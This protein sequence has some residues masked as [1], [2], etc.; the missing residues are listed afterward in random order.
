MAR[1]RKLWTTG[2]IADRLGVARQR[3]NQIVNDRREDFPEPFDTLPGGV[4][5]WLIDEVQ[6]WVREH[7]PERA[8]E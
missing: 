5:V 3:V 7:R 2:D 1:A 4:Q 6:A 8:E